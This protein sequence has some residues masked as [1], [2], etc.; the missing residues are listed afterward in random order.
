MEPMESKDELASSRDVLTQPEIEP[1]TAQTEVEHGRALAET[2]V[3]HGRTLVESSV[4]HGVDVV[5]SWGMGDDGAGSGGQKSSPRLALQS[6]PQSDPQVLQ[7]GSMVPEAGG[8][9]A[10]SSSVSPNTNGAGLCLRGEKPTLQATNRLVPPALDSLPPARHA[11]REGGIRTTVNTPSALLTEEYA[12]ENPEQVM[13]LAQQYAMVAQQYAS[14][15]Q[16]LYQH[17]NVMMQDNATSA[18]PPP[19]NAPSSGDQAPRSEPP[20]STPMMITPYRHN[21]LI[22]G[23][24]HADDDSS[25]FDGLKSDFQRSMSSIVSRVGGCRSCSPD[26]TGGSGWQCQQM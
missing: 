18:T 4:A 7:P 2:E 24:H 14:C 3:E 12:E 8:A 15:A 9:V 11:H 16:V 19:N 10:V 20:K 17:Y 1:E 6:L 13:Y 26:A 23:A 25:L 5:G 22:S 21:W